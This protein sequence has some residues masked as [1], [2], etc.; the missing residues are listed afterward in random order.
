MKKFIKFL[1]DYRGKETK[2]QFYKAGQIVAFDALIA[3][4]L[5]VDGRGVHFVSEPVET[6]QETPKTV[7]TKRKAKR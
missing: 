3:D 7:F 4:K 5:I 6:P 2:E 1:V